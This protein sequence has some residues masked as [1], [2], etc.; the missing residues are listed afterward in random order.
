MQLSTVLSPLS[1]ENLRLSS[2]CGVEGVVTRYPGATLEHLLAVKRRIESEG[3]QLVAIEGFLP[4]EKIK[5][6]ADHDGN[7][8]AAMKQLI[9]HMGEAGVPLL[10]YNF[11][12]GTDW[13]RTRLDAPER[14][15][16]RV[17]AFDL[18]E[19]EKAVSLNH[20]EEAISPNQITADTIDAEA[21]WRNLES[22]L[23]EVIPIAEEAGVT[24]AMHPDDPPLP[25]FLG[26]DRIM[27]RVENFERLVALVPSS[28]N[29][30]CF[31]SGTFATM[32]VDIP[33]TIRRL[34][35]HIR[36]VHFRDVR[37]T[38]E[39]FAETFHDNGPT[40]MAEAIRALKDIG[41]TGPIRPDHVPQLEGEDDG[42]PGYT[43]LGRLFAFG[44]IRG[45]LHGTRD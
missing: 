21:L 39:S 30:I 42:E 26:K 43:I 24:L 20:S 27:N 5:M 3:L 41:F 32:G 31:C 1:P 35:E 19:A 34:G 18:T 13:V 37:G 38:A 25:S 8:L 44:Y 6:G 11:M 4:I 9:R 14:G 15:G 16:A 29:A 2:Q 45:L 36:Y 17:T 10:C 40:E 23:L 22:F 7:E 12:A 28:R 33:A